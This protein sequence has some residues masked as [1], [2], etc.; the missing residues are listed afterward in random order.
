MNEDAKEMLGIIL[1]K[2]SHYSNNGEVIVSPDNM[3]INVY[4]KGEMDKVRLRIERFINE[5]N[6]ND[7]YHVIRFNFGLDSE[8]SESVWNEILNNLNFEREL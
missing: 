4:D 1:R 8:S 3:V 6:L 7:N 5:I 2:L